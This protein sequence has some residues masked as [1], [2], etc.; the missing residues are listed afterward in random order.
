VTQEE[1][2]EF[3]PQYRKKKKKKVNGGSGFIVHTAWL[4]FFCFPWTTCVCVTKI[5]YSF[6][7]L[8]NLNVGSEEF[9]LAGTGS[10]RIKK[11]PSVHKRWPALAWI[12]VE[13]AVF[14]IFISIFAEQLKSCRYPSSAM[15]LLI[16]LSK[17]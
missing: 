17:F 10:R 3:K 11:N 7:Y 6:C 13:M 8:K 4:T 9:I 14:A 16:F 2:P 1:G 15:D 5:L 12:L